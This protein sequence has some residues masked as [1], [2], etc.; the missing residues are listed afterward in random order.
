MKGP[1]PLM[2][3]LAISVKSTRPEVG[4]L[5][6]IAVFIENI[7]KIYKKSIP[8]RVWGRLGPARV[9]QILPCSVSVYI[10]PKIPLGYDR[11]GLLLSGSVR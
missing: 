11:L 2:C 3:L 10:Q 1:G 8:L 6:K 5:A 7:F 9:S 4:N